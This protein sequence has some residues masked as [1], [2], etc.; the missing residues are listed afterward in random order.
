[1]SK[2]L[3]L[4]DIAARGYDVEEIYPRVFRIHNFTLSGELE[5][6]NAAIA[7][8][9]EAAWTYMYLEQMRKNAMHKFGRD[10][11]DNL[12]A[13]GLLE[14]TDSWADKNAT[15]RGVSVTEDIHA[16]VVDIFDAVGGLE[17]TSFTT[18]QRMYEGV[19]LKSH[20]DQYSDKLVEYAAVLYLNDDYAAGE[21]FFPNFGLTLTPAAGDLVIFPGTKHYEHGVHP[22]G[23]GPIRYV[24][25]TF[26]KK[27][28]PDGAMAGW[29]EFGEK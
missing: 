9:D 26:I 27:L 2:I 23:S 5:A 15:I 14:V 20:Y 16:R 6:I 10:D 24:I 22:V 25:P 18:I 13:E 21:L 29:G 17:V 19:E 4:A 8:F 1:M 28:H 12:I 7:S 3:E 11:L